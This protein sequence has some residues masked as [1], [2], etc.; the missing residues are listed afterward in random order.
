MTDVV[1]IP[2]AIQEEATAIGASPGKLNLISIVLETFI[3]ECD[4]LKVTMYKSKK[5][6]SFFYF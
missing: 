5:K 1:C 3:F 6:K 2:S 4:L